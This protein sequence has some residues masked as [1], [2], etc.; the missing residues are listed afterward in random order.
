MGT[1]ACVSSLCRAAPDEGRTRPSRTTRPPRSGGVIGTARR[2]GR[3]DRRLRTRSPDS[4]VPAEEGRALT[5]LVERIVRHRS[6]V[7]PS[8][9]HGPHHQHRFFQSIVDAGE[10][11]RPPWWN[12]WIDAE[13]SAAA[14]SP[15][16]DRASEALAAIPSS[17]SVLRPSRASLTVP[18][19]SRPTAPGGGP[20]ARPGRGTRS[21]LHRARCVPRPS[22]GLVEAGRPV[23]RADGAVDP[24]GEP[25]PRLSGRRDRGP[26][27][28]T[29]ELP[30]R[31]VRRLRRAPV[32]RAR[33][34]TARPPLR[35]RRPIRRTPGRTARREAPGRA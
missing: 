21:P 12:S 6:L 13:T 19:P 31:K 2:T 3:G 24:S 29:G 25:M 34:R 15:S 33:R 4:G 16:A 27:D 35:M 5:E 10:P 26:R 8:H 23:V 20:A 1:V 17:G 28:G 11:A 18:R 14:S 32:P 22:P 9:R 7:Q 30:D